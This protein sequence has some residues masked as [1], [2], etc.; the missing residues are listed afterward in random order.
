MKASSL[1]SLVILCGALQASAFSVDFT[2]N[3]GTVLSN[4]DQPGSVSSMEIAVPGYGNVTI[5]ANQ[6]TTAVV[7][8]SFSNDNDTITALEFDDGDTVTVRFDGP[9]ALNVDFDYVGVSFGDDFDLVGIGAPPLNTLFVLE[10]E[11]DV[12]GGTGGLRSISFDAVPE[13]S[14]ALLSGLAVLTLLRRRR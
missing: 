12:A 14:S 8:Q 2:S 11:T 6:N 5:F 4:P 7:G 13:P 3:L 1:F 9:T 10:F